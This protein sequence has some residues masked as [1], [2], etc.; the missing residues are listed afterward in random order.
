MSG[1]LSSLA[2]HLKMPPVAPENHLEINVG[3]SRLSGH[4]V[5]SDPAR[6]TTQHA[7]WWRVPGGRLRWQDC[8]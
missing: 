5:I 3:G 2:E 1:Q 4:Y 8:D 6:L 7:T